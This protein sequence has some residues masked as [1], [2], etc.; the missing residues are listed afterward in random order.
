[1]QEIIEKVKIFMIVA[2]ICTIGYLLY[3]LVKEKVQIQKKDDAGLYTSG[4]SIGVAN[5]Q[6]D[7]YSQQA[8][9]NSKAF[10]I[11]AFLKEWKLHLLVLISM[12]FGKILSPL[13]TNTSWQNAGTFISGT[14]ILGT[15]NKNLIVETLA[16]GQAL[17]TG[18]ML[19]KDYYSLAKTFLN[20]KPLPDLYPV[21]QEHL[22][23]NQNS[24]NPKNWQLYD[25]TDES[26]TTGY[27]SK[28]F[29]NSGEP[30]KLLFSS[31][32]F[33]EDSNIEPGYYYDLVGNVSLYRNWNRMLAEEKVLELGGGFEDSQNLSNIRK[34]AG[35]I[36]EPSVRYQLTVGNKFMPVYNV[37]YITGHQFFKYKK[38][39]TY[40][41]ILVIY[42][43]A[44]PAA[45]EKVYK[46][47]IDK[48]NLPNKDAIRKAVSAFAVVISKSDNGKG[49]KFMIFT[50][51]SLPIEIPSFILNPIIKLITDKMMKSFLEAAKEY[52]K[53]QSKFE[54]NDDFFNQ[55]EKQKNVDKLVDILDDK[56]WRL[57]ATENKGYCYPYKSK[58]ISEDVLPEDYHDVVE[59]DVVEIDVREMNVEDDN[60]E[61]TYDDYTY[62]YTYT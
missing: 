20:E 61:Y 9:M 29:L 57:K 44:L 16:E 47:K 49:T 36:E 53:N 7:D 1:M 59:P 8:L 25:E 10:I 21:S 17:C 34:F 35:S 12:L 45:F 27:K 50:I 41:P 37:F 38:Y 43:H 13:K 54:S 19:K 6:D 22:Q 5:P 26:G 18:T 31:L 33:Y 58:S 30:G 56:S 40:E 15:S 3:L 60:D 46:S 51:E 23:L 28:L 48:M 14:S 62:L 4:S 24:L 2:C 32:S 55:L 11:K 52:R 39:S 42:G